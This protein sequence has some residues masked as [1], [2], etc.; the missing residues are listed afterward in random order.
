MRSFLP[1][2]T[3]TVFRMVTGCIILAS[4]LCPS[5]SRAQSFTATLRGTVTDS[6]GS[7]V[8]EAHVSL[9]NEA[10]NVK[11]QEKLTDA[12]VSDLDKALKPERAWQTS[13]GLE[14]PISPSASLTRFR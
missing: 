12:R 3:S 9:V 4:L 7:A 8:P 1:N 14:T 10:T 13:V 2:T 6:S 11:Q 5:G